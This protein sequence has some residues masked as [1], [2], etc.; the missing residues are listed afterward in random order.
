M[1]TFESEKTL[2]EIKETRN[3]LD[4]YDRERYDCKLFNECQDRLHNLHKDP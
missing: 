4:E 1:R 2:E 3:G